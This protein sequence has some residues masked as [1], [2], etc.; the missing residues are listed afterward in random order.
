M[1]GFVWETIGFATDFADFVGFP[2]F[3]ATV[4]A[5][6]LRPWGDAAFT[7]LVLAAAVAA[8]AIPVWG[9]PLP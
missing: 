6:L 1:T 8:G 4:R 5:E 9:R 7:G 3:A 2:G